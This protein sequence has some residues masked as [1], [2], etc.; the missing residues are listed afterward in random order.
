MQEIET[1]TVREYTLLMKAHRFHRV[2]REHDM[3]MEA[4][5]HRAAG[6]T[7]QVG[8]KEVGLYKKFKDF[9]DYEAR[10]KEIEAP[11]KPKLSKEHKRMAR[12][13]AKANSVN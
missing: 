10:V 4:W 9:F 11:K 8:Q 1:L 5:L 13:A 3:H 7:K 6:A 2:D 12:L